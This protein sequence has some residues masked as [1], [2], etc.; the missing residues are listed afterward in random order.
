MVRRRKQARRSSEAGIIIYFPSPS[1]L[2]CDKYQLACSEGWSH[3]VCM[4]HVTRHMLTQFLQDYQNNE[5]SIGFRVME[6]VDIE[7]CVN[8]VTANVVDRETL[9]N[10]QGITYEEFV[11]FITSFVKKGL[12][13]SIVA[14]DTRLSDLQNNVVG[15]SISVDHDDEVDVESLNVSEK[16]TP[17]M[18]ILDEVHFFS[19][20]S[21]E[22][23]M[24]VKTTSFKAFSKQ[25]KSL[26][27]CNVAVDA[28]YAGKGYANMLIEKNIELARR[29]GYEE[30]FVETTA[31]GSL[32][33]SLNA[34]FKAKH[35]IK[36]HAFSY[37]DEDTG[38]KVHPFK[39]LESQNLS[40]T[41]LTID[42]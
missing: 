7:K 38:R 19:P 36:V 14:Y 39:E 4:P 31:P 26:H 33:A 24:S 27:L 23:E 41:Y 32:K 12:G 30:M 8:C 10:F 6:E 11:P 28:I 37:V 29:L 13:T 5:I 9:T 18:K 20:G 34:G 40:V 42:L 25:K 35:S 17:I 22:D 21:E 3:I 15:C 16:F 1:E 2:I